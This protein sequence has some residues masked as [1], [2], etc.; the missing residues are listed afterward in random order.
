[1][2]LAQREHA[3]VR[4]LTPQIKDTAGIHESMQQINNQINMWITQQ[5]ELARVMA[6]AVASPADLSRVQMQ[7]QE[8]RQRI[9]SQQER[10]STATRE[11]RQ[12]ESDVLRDLGK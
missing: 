8:R 2:H 5:A 4:S 7:T 12:A 1:M 11:G 9:L 3:A 10:S 6:S